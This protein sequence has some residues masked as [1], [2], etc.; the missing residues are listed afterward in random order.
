MRPPYLQI[1]VELVEQVAPDIAVQL[2][3]EEAPVGW[4]ILKLYRWA[5]GRCPENKPPSASALVSGPHAAKLVARAA[6]LPV[7]LADAF[8]EAGEASSP[9]ILQRVAGGIRI[10][11]M[12]RYDAYWGKCNPSLWRAYKELMAA[13]EDPDRTNPGARPVQSRAGT[14]AEPVQN[15]RNSSFTKRAPEHPQEPEPNGWPPEHEPEPA[16][17]REKEPIRRN[18]PGTG[19]EPAQVRYELDPEP[20]RKIINGGGGG[21][22]EEQDGFSE[23]LSEFSEPADQPTDLP[24]QALPSSEGGAAEDFVSAR[25]VDRPFGRRVIE[26]EPTADG[27]WGFIQL[28]RECNNLAPEA[29]RPLGFDE[30]AAE[31]IEDCGSGA[32]ERMVLDYLHDP[33]IRSRTRATAVLFSDRML[34]ARRPPPMRQDPGAHP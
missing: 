29:S 31:L 14:G 28:V 8:V 33:S 17:T 1:A 30:K 32:F 22:E 6:G 10:R 18:R 23:E 20:P 13:S 34:A 21:I 27:A 25:W 2:D 15:R 7:E 12:G 24:D 11:G 16:E 4:G 3:L 19:P 26:W 5:L 9:P